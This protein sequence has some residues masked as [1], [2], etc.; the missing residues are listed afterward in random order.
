VFWRR[1]GSAQGGVVSSEDP[2]DCSAVD[3]ELVVELVDGGAAG[4]VG[5][6]QLLGIGVIGLLWTVTVG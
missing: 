2:T 6:D 5:R 1:A 4:L 3:A